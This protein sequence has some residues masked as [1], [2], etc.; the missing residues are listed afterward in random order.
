MIYSLESLFI[1]YRLSFLLFEACFTSTVCKLLV[2][3]V[4]GLSLKKCKCIRMSIY[5]TTKLIL[6]VCLF[7]APGLCPEAAINLWH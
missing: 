5:G 7:T 3:I 4:S 6:Y 2:T 1:H